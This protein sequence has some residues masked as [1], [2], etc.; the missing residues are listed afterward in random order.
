[1]FKRARRKE[2]EKNCVSEIICELLCMRER[3]CVCE[4]ESE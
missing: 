3:E 2:S 4:L 1:V